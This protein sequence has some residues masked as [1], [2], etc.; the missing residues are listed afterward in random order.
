MKRLCTETEKELLYKNK[1]QM[2]DGIYW[3]ATRSKVSHFLTRTFLSCVVMIIIPVLAT[4][5]LNT[6]PI[7]SLI[8][9]VIS[10]FVSNI[11]IFAIMSNI[12]VKQEA[13]KF[14]NKNNLM[15]NGATIVDVYDGNGFAY[16][17]DDLKDENGK[18]IIIE[19]P[20]FTYDVTPDE[21]GKRIIVMYDGDSDFQLIKL[22]DELRGLVYDYSTF[23]PI[24]DDLEE[25]IRVPHPN[26]LKIEK[27]DHMLSE[28]EKISYADLYVNT[29]QN[30]AVNMLKK[31]LC[32][33]L[34]LDIIICGLLSIA[35][36]GVPL[37]KSLPI[38]IGAWVCFIL[39][40]CVIMPIGN[41]NRKRQARFEKVKQVVFQS[42]ITDENRFTVRVFEWIDGEIRLCEYFAGNVSANTKYGSILYK[43]TNHKGEDVLLNINK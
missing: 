6:S 39:F 14:L 33:I 4:Y 42:Y 8:L 36:G 10:F 37:S 9:M 17:E 27:E 41:I 3:T 31:S 35:E 21:I 38:G 30:I 34:V 1:N 28:S 15:I 43:F 18:P 29:V 24:S 2:L 22:N 40:C 25:Y 20:S 32:F 7:I 5:L 16:I 12:S 19:Y 13:K 23:E 26:M 11:I